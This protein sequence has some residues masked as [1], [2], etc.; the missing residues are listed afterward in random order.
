LE[1]LFQNHHSAIYALCRRLLGSADDAQDAT[2]AAFVHAFRELHRFRG[3][4]SLRTWLYRIAVNEATGQLRRRARVRDADPDEDR[5][6]AGLD[7]QIAVRLALERVK[8]AHRTVLVLR[9][10]EGLS[11]EEIGEVLRISLPAVKM[12]LFR[13]REE[14]RRFYEEQP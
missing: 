13:A 1:H 6:P 7:E 12:R 8:P 5:Q 3:D 9:F 11:Y 14:F 4:C 2:Q 10:W